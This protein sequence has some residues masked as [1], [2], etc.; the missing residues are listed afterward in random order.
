MARKPI[1][2][3]VGSAQ[4]LAEKLGWMGAIERPTMGQGA[5]V[6][7]IGEMVDVSVYALQDMLTIVGTYAGPKDGKWSPVV[8]E[9]LSRWNHDRF[10][11]VVTP[12]PED[13]ETVSFRRQ[14]F[15][16]LKADAEAAVGRPARPWYFWPL[17]ITG[18]V[19]GIYLLV[20]MFSK[21]AKGGGTSEFAVSRRSRRLED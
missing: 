5:D 15:N 14:V 9:A 6:P 8:M 2:R 3:G 17:V 20:Y 13:P 1:V 4:E 21:A 19:A 16:A 7:E 11:L 10:Q 12:K 18:T